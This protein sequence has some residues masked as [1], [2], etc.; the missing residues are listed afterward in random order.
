MRALR[1]I[2]V[3]VGLVPVFG[4]V[5]AVGYGFVGPND[6]RVTG[7]TDVGV[8]AAD[9][10]PLTEDV[11]KWRN[12]LLVDQAD[13]AGFT[14][15]QTAQTTGAGARLEWNT[16]FETGGV[17]LINE[18]QDEASYALDFRERR[19]GR[20][21]QTSSNPDAEPTS[22]TVSEGS[23]VVEQTA[24]GV[25]LTLGQRGTGGPRPLG[26]FLRGSVQKKRQSEVDR[27]LIALGE[28]AERQAERRVLL[29]AAQVQ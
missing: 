17:M 14:T 22:W 13:V 3:F 8:A 28:Q 24:L 10:I 4:L 27:R 6:W 7:S 16:S 12:W 1:V 19:A 20:A 9:V 18:W 23:L 5:G 29:E 11:R 15:V 21:R 26:P 2:L 25:R